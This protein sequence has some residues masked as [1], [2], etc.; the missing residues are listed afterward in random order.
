MTTHYMDEAEFCDRIAIM[1][2]GEI[3]VLDTPD[4]AEGR[5]SAPTA[6][7]S[8]TADDDAAL[9]ALRERFGL[10]AHGRRGRGDVLRRPTARR[11]SRGCSPSSTSPITSVSVS[12]PTLDDVFMSLHRLDDPRR[13][14]GRRQATA[15]GSM[16]RRWRGRGDERDRHAPTS[17]ASAS[18]SARWRSELRAI[19]IVWTRELIRFRKDRMRIVTSLIQPLLFLFVLGSG[20]QTLS[21]AGTD[22]VDLK[23]FIFPGDPLHG[24]D[25]HRDVHAPPRSCGTASSASCAR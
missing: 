1:D 11:S 10:E 21:G 16:M 25:V 13:G 3:V 15:T 18:R 6:C 8:S 14:G 22:G 5:R 7:G 19:K 24:G 17:S 12:R 4:G 2:Q 20:L 9:A 23:T